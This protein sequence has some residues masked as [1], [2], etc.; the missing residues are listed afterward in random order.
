MDHGPVKVTMIIVALTILTLLLLN[1][2]AIT[3]YPRK[4]VGAYCGNSPEE[5]AAFR[6]LINASVYPNKVE[7]I[8][9]DSA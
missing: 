6:T 9:V 1:G 8:C 2:C 7:L 5:R 3:S 4:A